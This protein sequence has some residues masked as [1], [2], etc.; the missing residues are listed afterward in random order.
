MTK[1]D[2]RPGQRV[3]TLIELANVPRGSEGVIIEVYTG[4]FMVGWLI[5]GWKPE[6]P[7]E[8]YS[9]NNMAAVDPRCPLRDGFA[10]NEMD[11]L[12]AIK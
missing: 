12:E 6:L 5:E 2:V 7:I 10:Y 11:I 8:E 9:I 4:G 1:E 3:K